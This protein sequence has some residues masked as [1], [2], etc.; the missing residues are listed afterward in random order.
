[1]YSCLWSSL[2][3]CRDNSSCVSGWL[4]ACLSVES[5]LAAFSPKRRNLDDNEPWGW[6]N[7]WI[8]SKTNVGVRVWDLQLFFSKLSKKHFWR[9]RENSYLKNISWKHVQCRLGQ[10][11]L[12]S[13]KF[14]EFSAISTLTSQCGKIFRQINYICTYLF[15]ATAAFTKFLPKPRQRKLPKFSHSDTV[16]LF[17]RF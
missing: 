5:T 14:C 12:I 16:F 8:D 13:H 3:V 4:V 10:T 1:M 15:S 6:M 7:N 11:Q 17:I 9:K 2:C